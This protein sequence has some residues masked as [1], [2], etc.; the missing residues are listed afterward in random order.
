[1]YATLTPRSLASTPRLAA[2]RSASEAERGDPWLVVTE[3]V[4]DRVAQGALDL[5]GAGRGRSRSRARAC[6]GRSRAGARRGRGR[7]SRRSTGRRRAPPRRGR[8]RPPARGRS[9]TAW[10]GGAAL[11]KSASARSGSHVPE[12]PLVPARA[13]EV[14]PGARAFRRAELGPETVP[15]R[16]PHRRRSRSSAHRGGPA[17]PLKQGLAD[18]PIDPVAGQHCPEQLGEGAAVGGGD[19]VARVGEVCGRHRRARH[20]SSLSPKR[21]KKPSWSERSTAIAPAGA[22]PDV[23]QSG[24]GDRAL[25]DLR[26]VA[27]RR[28]PDEPVAGTEHQGPRDASPGVVRPDQGPPP[29]EELVR[30]VAPGI[31]SD[32]VRAPALRD[33]DHAPGHDGIG[34]P[35]AP[36]MLSRARQPPRS[37]PLIFQRVR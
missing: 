33:G 30:S 23:P 11:P 14:T 34:N 8:R 7:W 29:A 15:G 27:Q 24:M 36:R 16:T 37:T 17:T 2:A 1:M 4:C 12:H 20:V 19:Q 18:L 5:A 32:G 26:A 22:R 13:G 25:R 31:R 10:L 28:R 21:A 9:P 3:V 35:R 6:P